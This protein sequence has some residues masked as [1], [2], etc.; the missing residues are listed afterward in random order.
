MRFVAFEAGSALEAALVTPQ[1]LQQ[2]SS[3]VA[4]AVP[5]EWQQA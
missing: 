1:W 5:V 3:A 4:R 2:L